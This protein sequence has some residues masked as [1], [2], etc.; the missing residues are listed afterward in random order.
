MP[1]LKLISE[2]TSLFELIAKQNKAISHTSTS[3]KF[4]DNIEDYLLDG[5][6]AGKHLVIAWSQARFIDNKS[7]NVFKPVTFELWILESCKVN[8]REERLRILSETERVATSIVS[9]LRKLVHDTNASRIL[10]RIEENA[11]LMDGMGPVGP[12]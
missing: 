8:D 6:V 11:I 3:R 4:F 5:N 10:N 2:Y 7:D 1:Q 12:N 9:Y